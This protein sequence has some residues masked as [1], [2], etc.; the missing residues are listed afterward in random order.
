MSKSAKSAAHL[1]RFWGV[2]GS[3]PTADLEQSLIGGNTSCVELTAAD[4]CH[5]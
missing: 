4:G 5:I 3:I 2:R 1:L